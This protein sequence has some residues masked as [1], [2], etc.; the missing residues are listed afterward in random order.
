MDDE[1]ANNAAV[2]NCVFKSDDFSRKR[3]NSYP[4]PTQRKKR[5]LDALLDNRLEELMKENV[6]LKQQLLSMTVD[7]DHWKMQ[8]ET[9]MSEHV[10]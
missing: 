9:V 6:S 3:Q 5:K 10:S 7:R 8:Y 4:S 1:T 2:A